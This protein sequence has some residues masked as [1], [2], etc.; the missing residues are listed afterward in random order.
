[1]DAVEQAILHRLVGFTALY[2]LPPGGETP[3]KIAWKNWKYFF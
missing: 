1:M 2:H 3:R